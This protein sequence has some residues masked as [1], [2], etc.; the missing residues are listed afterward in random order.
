MKKFNVAFPL[1]LQAQGSFLT[2]E[3]PI[4]S[5]FQFLLNF[6]QGERP[7]FQEYGTRLEDLEQATGELDL[8]IPLQLV[9][10]RTAVLDFIT[11]IQLIG[12]SVERKLIP[13]REVQFTVVY[14][15]PGGRVMEKA[16]FEQDLRFQ[17]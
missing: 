16:T 12:V 6:R 17:T 10:L 1:V 11:G 8:L 7:R 14:N 3:R 4:S 2:R 15:V 5:R 13:R 9:A